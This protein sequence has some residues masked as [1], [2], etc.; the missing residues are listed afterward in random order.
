MQLH[1]PFTLAA[2]EDSFEVSSFEDELRRNQDGGDGGTR[3]PS[4]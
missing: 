3:R 4:V 1:Q 2:L